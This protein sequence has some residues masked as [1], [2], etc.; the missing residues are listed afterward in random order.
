[1]GLSVLRFFL[2]HSLQFHALHAAV[3]TVLITARAIGPTLALGWLLERIL[4]GGWTA[5]GMQCTAVCVWED[6]LLCFGGLGV[7]VAGG[8]CACARVCACIHAR[9]RSVHNC[10]SS[11]SSVTCTAGTSVRSA[12]SGFG[13]LIHWLSRQRVR[14]LGRI[15]TSSWELST[16]WTRL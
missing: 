1:M 8:L 12:K 15:S 9:M 6:L 10:C 7:P 11:V 16:R 3:E 5:R 13:V 2:V 4:C 14:L